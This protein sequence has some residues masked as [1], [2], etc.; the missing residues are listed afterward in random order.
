MN[1]TQGEPDN[2]NLGRIQKRKGWIP[3]TS[4]G[5]TEQGIIEASKNDKSERFPLALVEKVAAGE[6]PIKI[7]REYRELSQTELAKHVSVSRQY[8]SQLESNER[9]GTAKILKVI[10]KVLQVELEDII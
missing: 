5:T 9:T 6:N 3:R 8:I 2:E 1:S 10:A 7:F 4:R